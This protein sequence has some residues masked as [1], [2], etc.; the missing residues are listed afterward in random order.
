MATA[1]RRK[2]ASG[3]AAHAASSRDRR[4]KASR[5][6]RPM[7]ARARTELRKGIF[8]T[9]QHAP[10]PSRS[11]DAHLTER[12][13]EGF[14]NTF[15]LGDER[16]QPASEQSAGNLRP[17][18]QSGT[19][20]AS[21]MRSISQEVSNFIQER[22]HEN[23]TRLVALAYCRTPPQLVAAQRDLIGDNVAGFVRSTGRITDLSMRM[24]YEGVRRMSAVS[25]APQ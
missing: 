23:F 5:R 24:A 2:K 10:E 12:S 18:L 6:K 21:A 13:G 20:F 1:R 9:V 7:A 22:M 14:T 11:R 8:P 4:A 16:A 19:I 3:R 15:G 25:L 17:V